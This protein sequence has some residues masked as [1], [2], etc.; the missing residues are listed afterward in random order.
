MRRSAL[1]LL[2]TMGLLALVLQ[3]K[4]Q[5]CADSDKVPA[6]T[7]LAGNYTYAGDRA[8]DEGAIK[9]K[10]DA[11]TA[12]MGRMVLKRARPALES[13]TR[14]P[15]RLIITRQGGNLTFKADDHV[16]T[17]P[18]NG[19]AA[20]VLTPLGESA[21]ASFDVKTATLQQTVTATGGRK[22][23]AFRFDEAG[24]LVMKVR[25]T[26]GRLAAPV[27]FT[28]LYARANQPR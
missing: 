19:T 14:V 2:G 18:E 6:L 4:S 20:R 25:I 27:A 17:V 16:V 22:T 7:E 12:D 3:L 9:A 28:L 26:N 23:N 10:S 11:A 1:A 24:K 21:E 5:A 8:K 13:S 15:E